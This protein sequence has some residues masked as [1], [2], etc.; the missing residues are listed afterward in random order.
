M[1]SFK[2]LEPIVFFPCR[3]YNISVDYIDQIL[4]SCI[5]KIIRI[6]FYLKLMS[7]RST[8][9][10]S[11]YVLFFDMQCTLLD[12]FLRCT[13]WCDLNEIEEI[14]IGLSLNSG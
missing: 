3:F 11:K 12:F 1:Y 10:L 4:L 6:N 5:S 7:N 2:A 9:I 14:S 13:N 8:Y